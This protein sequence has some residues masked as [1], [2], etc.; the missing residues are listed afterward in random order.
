MIYV[1][2]HLFI[3]FIS[4]DPLTRAGV[5]EISNGSLY[6]KCLCRLHWLCCVTFYYSLQMCGGYITYCQCQHGLCGRPRPTDPVQRKG[7]VG[8]GCGWG[9]E[10]FSLF[11]I[12][13]VTSCKDLLGDSHPAWEVSLRL[14]VV[15]VTLRNSSAFGE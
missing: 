8:V 5:R 4:D 14:L 6:H 1:F 3:V 9:G 7:C 12:A 11:Q 2:I 13:S 10:D 15:K